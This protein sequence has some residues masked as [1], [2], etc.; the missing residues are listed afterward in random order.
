[1]STD[2]DKFDKFVGQHREG[3]VRYALTLQR[4][5]GLAQDLV[6]QTFRKMWELF[7]ASDPSIQLNRFLAVTILK[8]TLIAHLRREKGIEIGGDVTGQVVVGDHNIVIRATDGSAVTLLQ[9]GELPRPV[10][11]PRIM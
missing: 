9:P 3:L 4:D 8:D 5:P 7:T 2:R 10:R 1:M 11:R 6:Q